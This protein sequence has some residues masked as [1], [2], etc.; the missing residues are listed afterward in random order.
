M[1]D[2]QEAL[3]ALGI[4][5]PAGAGYRFRGIQFVQNGLRVAADFPEGY[6]VGIR[7]PILHKLLIQR[8]EDCGVKLLWKTPVIGIAS[9]GVQVSGGVLPARWILG[10]DGSGSRIRK[11]SGLEASHLRTQRHA[12]RRHYRVRPWSDLME[13]YWGKRAQ[14]YVTPISNEE[15]CIV[16]MAD[17]AEGAQFE[18][19]L[20]DMPEL[21]EKIAKAKQGSR[22]RGAITLMHTLRR[23]SRGNVALVGDASGGVDAI[24][25]EGMRLTFQQASA[26]A[27]AMACGDLRGYEKAH[28]RMSMRPLW[29]GK[30]ILHLGRR[31]GLRG[32]VLRVFAETPELFAQL[33]SIHVGRATAG[34]VLSTGA[35]LGW[36]FL[37]A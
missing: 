17:H 1:P 25:G 11:W 37:A 19:V 32:R 9:E 21:R 12:T 31:A 8:A 7:R 10:A 24:T 26:I 3:A 14:A 16:M 18:R 33:L 35:Q 6:G 15:V 27:E 34:Q 28:R 22:E 2:T 23:V 30:L 36:Q 5:L 29:M 4:R 20:A 13:I